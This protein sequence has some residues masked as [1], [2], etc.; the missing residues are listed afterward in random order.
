MSH[1]NTELSKDQFFVPEKKGKYPGDAVQIIGLEGNDVKFFNQGGGW[2]QS[3]PKEKF[4]KIFREV[5]EDEKA[6]PKPYE[7]TFGIDDY[8]EPALEGYTLGDKWNGW[9]MPLFGKESAMRI[10]EQFGDMT[11]DEER[12]VFI[13]NTQEYYPDEPNEEFAGQDIMVNGETV[14]VY[15]I[16]A[17]FWTWDDH[18]PNAAQK[19]RAKQEYHQDHSVSGE[20][21][22]P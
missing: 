14:R 10:A 1:S 20:S 17:G 7:S 12:D 5:T 16:G 2:Q 18:G 15:P 8:F 11:Y 22:S 19:A 21:P 3:L 4:L 13:L 9:A 6:N